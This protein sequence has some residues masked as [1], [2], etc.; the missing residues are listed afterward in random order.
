MLPP[1]VA[2]IGLLAALGPQRHPRRAVEDAGIQ[3]VLHTAGVVVAL[4]FVAAPFYLRQAQARRSRPSTATWLRRLADARRQRGAH[5]PARR[6]PRGAARAW[7][8]ASALAWGRALGEFGATLMF[9]GSFR[10]ITQTVPLAIYDRFSTDFTGALALSAVL[11][12]RLRRA[13][14]RR[15]SSLSG[16]APARR[17][18]ALTPPRGSGRSRS[19]SRSRSRP[20]A[21]LA[22]AG[23]SGA[24]KT[25]RAA[26]RRRAR[27]PR[28]RARAL[29]R[30][31]SGWT[32]S[33]A[34]TSRP[35]ARRCGYVFQDYALFGHLS[36]WQNVAYALR[37]SPRASAASARC[38]L[39]DRF[40]LAHRADARPRTLSG[41][42]RQRVALARA[43]AREPDALL[44]DE[45]LSA[46][47]ARTRAARRPRARRRPAET[48][49]AD[50]ARHARLRRGGAARRPR[51]RHRRRPRRAA[52]HRR[53]ARRLARVG[54][55]RRLHRRRRPHRAPRAPGDG[56]LTS[57]ALDGG[58]ERRQHRPGEGAVAASVYPW[59]IA[60]APAGTER[61]GSAQNHLDVRVVSVTDGRQSR[62]PRARGAPAADRRV[63]R[64]LGAELGLDPGVSVVATW[65][66]S[67]TRL[68]RL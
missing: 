16:S 51:R 21:C 32:P 2:G 24:G 50:A 47:D 66:A 20:G 10:G 14:A 52:R 41:G 55:R 5:V 17:C 28:P 6:D 11:V 57:V 38:E 39:L 64:R 61:S 4:T 49:R 27:A 37:A 19:T 59:E 1:A 15:S 56:G 3:L 62:P 8:P 18:C 7:S 29:R 33:P 23:P 53:R 36:A 58:G 13:A 31:R 67:A 65:K 54:V 45:P 43:L 25:T 9:A 48:R 30:A 46:L 22:L 42:E 34:S 63:Q 12:A 68:L 40:G 35:S 26:H 60:L 44:L